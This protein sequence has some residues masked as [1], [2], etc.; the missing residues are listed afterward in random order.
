MHEVYIDGVRYVPAT[1]QEQLP[2]LLNIFE[3][4]EMLSVPAAT[5]RYWRHLGTGPKAFRMGRHLRFQKEDVVAWAKEMQHP[6][7]EENN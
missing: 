1:E 2:E 5:L 3:V 4:S 6:N 7:T